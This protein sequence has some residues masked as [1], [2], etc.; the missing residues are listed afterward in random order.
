MDSQNGILIHSPEL[1]AQL[2]ALFDQV[3]TPAYSY[4]V[5][6]KGDDLVWT[7]EQAGKPIEYHDDPETGWWR[8]FKSSLL[9][10]LSP[11]KWSVIGM[12]RA[13]NDSRSCSRLFERSGFEVLNVTGKTIIPVRSNKKLLE[14]PDAMEQIAEARGG[15]VQRFHFT[16]GRAAHRANR[17]EETGGGWVTRFQTTK[18]RIPGRMGGN[19][20]SFIVS[21]GGK[22]GED[23]GLCLVD[24]RRSACRYLARIHANIPASIF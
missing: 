2:A 13:A 7:G 17:R 12:L 21:S 19:P 11:E 24:H 9:G 20:F 5:G 1:A 4:R 23:W 18:P 15:A 10:G 16:A 3:T 14:A 6:L 22:I 8:R